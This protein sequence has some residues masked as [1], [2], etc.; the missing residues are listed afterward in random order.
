MFIRQERALSPD[1]QSSMEANFGADTGAAGSEQ[2]QGQQG[3]RSYNE[4]RKLQR[5]LEKQT[6]EMET[7]KGEFAPLKGQLTQFQRMFSGAKDDEGEEK[8]TYVDR[9]RRADRSIRESDPSSNGLAL[10]LEGAEL[11][12]ELRSQNAQMKQQ[13]ER[14]N[15]P[16]H[17]AEQ[18]L[19]IN[20]EGGIREEIERFFGEAGVDDNYPDFERVA[21]DRLR[22]VQKDPKKWVAFLRSK[23]A[24]KQ[25]VKAV[26]TAKMP[27]LDNM[28]GW[29][30]IDT[31]GV[32]DAQ[33]DLQRSEAMALK[34]KQE[35]NRDMYLQASQLAQKARQRLLPE[36]LGLRFK[37]DM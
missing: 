25:F 14:M 19:F 6:R 17:N 34:A 3:D 16:Q 26:I 37:D 15:T 13:M 12:E 22:E 29:K 30:K 9:V 5:L 2:P 35:K 31:Y 8:L 36:T 32:Q 7:L 28:P 23:E 24:Q 27:K 1:P 18:M 20:I 11:L 33:R 21:I 10:T 4:V